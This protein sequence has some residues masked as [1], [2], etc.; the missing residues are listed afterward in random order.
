MAGKSVVYSVEGCFYITSVTCSAI[1]CSNCTSVM[2]IIGCSVVGCYG[3]PALG[4]MGLTV[5]WLGGEE[6]SLNILA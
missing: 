3:G 1:I 6:I 5:A 4:K 2:C